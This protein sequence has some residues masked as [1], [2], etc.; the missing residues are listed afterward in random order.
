[1]W[2]DIEGDK[3]A[4]EDDGM[5]LVGSGTKFPA[6]LELIVLRGGMYEPS[7]ARGSVQNPTPNREQLHH[8]ALHQTDRCGAGSKAI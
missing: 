3:G 2:A 1:M 4:D 5:G 6:H 8:T 7:D